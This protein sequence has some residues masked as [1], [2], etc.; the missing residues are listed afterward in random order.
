MEFNRRDFEEHLSRGTVLSYLQ[1]LGRATDGGYPMFC[2]FR[3]A[4]KD[5]N[6]EKWT[7]EL[8][9]LDSLWSGK[10]LKR[11]NSGR[12]DGASRKTFQD[13]VCHDKQKKREESMKEQ[14]LNRLWKHQDRY[15][16]IR[17][18]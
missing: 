6:V 18:L 3:L 13:S 7:K 8:N 2:V 5:N 9:V 10:E 16:M 15:F 14:E 12:R 17:L 1:T 4:T 11:F